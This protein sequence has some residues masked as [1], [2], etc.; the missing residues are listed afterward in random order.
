MLRHQLA[1]ELERILAGRV[2][3]LIHE[4]LEVDGIVVELGSRTTTDRTQRNVR[5]AAAVTLGFCPPKVTRK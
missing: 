1:A 4:A 3:Q 2:R 5:T